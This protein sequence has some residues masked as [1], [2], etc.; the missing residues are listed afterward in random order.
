MTAVTLTLNG[1]PVSADIEPRT[2]LGD[3]VREQMLLTATHLGCEHGVCGACTV[4]IDGAPARS[5][6][7]FPVALD[8]AEITTLEGLAD[9]PVMVRLRDA[10][11]EAHALQ[12]GYCTPGML[13]MARDIVLRLPGAS[14]ETIRHQLAGNLCRC[15]GYIG[16]VKAI[17]TVAAER[18]GL[19]PVVTR[20]LAGPEVALDPF[21][22][23]IGGAGPTSA[24]AVPV[25]MADAAPVAP[26]EPLVDPVELKQHFDVPAAP[27]VVFALFQ[28]P[29]RV[30]GCL[31]GARLTAPSDGKTIAAELGIRL[32]PISAAFAGT[33]TISSDPATQSGV[34][35]GR[36]VDGKSST[37]VRARLAYRLEP[38]AD[39]AAT[40]VIADVALCI[41]GAAGAGQ[42][43]L[44]RARSRG[45]PDRDLCRQSRREPD[46]CSG[47]QS[48]A[49]RCRQPHLCAREGLVRTAVRD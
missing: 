26:L 27:D 25:P 17:Q 15:T 9:D 45:T 28:D 48:P 5:C 18:V 10:F 12:C 22:K 34:I 19:A 13:I 33:G 42:P 7:A 37:R 6:I 21:L 16:I 3:F 29:E 14:P 24:K 44:D 36:G 20:G 11:S 38:M 2:H 39:G 40:R 32:G 41:A 23:A 43:W 4:L 46:G 8:G 35:D 47:R 1:T 49:A 30:I 31:P